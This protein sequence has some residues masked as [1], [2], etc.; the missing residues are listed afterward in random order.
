MKVAISFLL[1]LAMA[2]GCEGNAPTVFLCL[3]AVPGACDSDDD[4]TLGFCQERGGRQVCSEYELVV[5]V[6]EPDQDFV[7]FVEGVDYTITY[8]TDSCEL[9]MG[10]TFQHGHLPSQDAEIEMVWMINASAP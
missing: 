6:K 9:G 2:I 7:E 4:C 5:R 8:Q 3:D 1:F 10:I